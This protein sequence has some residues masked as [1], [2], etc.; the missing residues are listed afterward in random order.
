[1]AV[2]IYVTDKVHSGADEQ[3]AEQVEVHTCQRSIQ[4][5]VSRKVEQLTIN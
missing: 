4:S 2:E 3:I 1:M 5:S